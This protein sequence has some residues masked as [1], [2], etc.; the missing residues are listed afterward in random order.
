MNELEVVGRDAMAGTDVDVVEATGR[1][2]S[3][4]SEQLMRIVLHVRTDT[5]VFIMPCMIYYYSTKIKACLAGRLMLTSYLPLI[6]RRAYLCC[7]TFHCSV[8]TGRA[9]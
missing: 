8:R 9:Y 7:L 3:N 1:R 5:G 2:Q 6:T 4:D